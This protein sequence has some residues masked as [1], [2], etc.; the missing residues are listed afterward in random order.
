[1]AAVY[2]PTV[3]PRP[4]DSITW[5][6]DHFPSVLL[7]VSENG[8]HP[9]AGIEGMKRGKRDDHKSIIEAL[10]RLQIAESLICWVGLGFDEL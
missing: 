2:S 8:K 4:E 1:M 5:V 7:K 3:Y 6:R 9:S 10:R